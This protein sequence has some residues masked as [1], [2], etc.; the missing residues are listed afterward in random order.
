MPR[1]RSARLHRGPDPLF[2]TFQAGDDQTGVTL[3]QLT[4]QYDAGAILS[5]AATPIETNESLPLLE[6]RLAR[7]GANLVGRLIDN[8]PH[9]PG[10]VPQDGPV[11]NRERWPNSADRMIDADWTADRARRFIAGVAT[12]HGPLAYRGDAQ[13]LSI[14]GLAEPGQGHEI[15]LRD[16]SLFVA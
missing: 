1:D 5:Q 11:D 15:R 14:R 3:H 4:D 8:L 7:M 12:T 2:W 10:P 13:L 9:L 16:E 6:Q